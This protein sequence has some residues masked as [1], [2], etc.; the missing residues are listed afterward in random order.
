MLILS[1]YIDSNIPDINKARLDFAS[2]QGADSTVLVGGEM[3]DEELVETVLEKFEGQPPNVAI[4]CSG[5]ESA[6]RLAILVS[7]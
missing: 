6:T 2:Q 5:T 3:T 1:L 7:E 4:E